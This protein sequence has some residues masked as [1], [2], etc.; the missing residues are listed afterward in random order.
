[1]YCAPAKTSKAA[2]SVRA[3]RHTDMPRTP[4]VST[5]HKV[6]TERRTAQ[7][8]DKTKNKKVSCVKMFA[9]VWCQ[10]SQTVKCY[11]ERSLS[12][13]LLTTHCKAWKMSPSNLNGFIS[14]PQRTLPGHSHSS[15]KVRLLL[16]IWLLFD[17]CIIQTHTHNIKSNFDIL[18]S[19]KKAELAL[20]W[21]GRH[22]FNQSELKKIL[23]SWPDEDTVRSKC[24]L[25]C[26]ILE[27]PTWESE[28]ERVW[29]F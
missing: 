11:F 9:A 23:I 5:G 8:A 18:V 29:S 1:M 13:R 10:I 26:F 24:R 17:Y 20:F 21:S 15:F 28:R 14:I 25:C 16:F 12:S 2:R 27:L 22:L 19:F 3:Q 4:K 7:Q 6:G